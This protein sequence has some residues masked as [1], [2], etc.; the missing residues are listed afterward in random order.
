MDNTGNVSTV[1]AVV[2]LLTGLALLA[3]FVGVSTR[4]DGRFTGFLLAASLL[5]LA[6][7][8]DT[9]AATGL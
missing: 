9:L 8:T 2:C 6:I 7:G 1:A 3:L 4:T 5:L